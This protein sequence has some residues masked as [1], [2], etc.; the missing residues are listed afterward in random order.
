MRPSP[1]ALPSSFDIS[2][3]GRP[4]NHQ[5]CERTGNLPWKDEQHQRPSTELFDINLNSVVFG[6]KLGIPHM[7]K[8]GDGPIV[9]LGSAT[10]CISIS[11]QPLYAASKHAVLGLARCTA[12]I[13][14]AAESCIYISSVAPWLTLTSMVEGYPGDDSPGYPSKLAGRCG[15]GD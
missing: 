15:V 14:E 5:P 4:D 12:H 8:H 3:A 6:Q 10:S 7:K 11:S 1:R 2:D 13:G 9:V